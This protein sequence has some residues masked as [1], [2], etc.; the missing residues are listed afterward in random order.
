MPFHFQIR[1]GIQHAAA[2]NLDEPRL[3]ATVVD[4]WRAGTPIEVGDKEWD[5][6]ESKLRILE[7]PELEPSRLDFGRGWDEA[8]RTAREVTDEMLAE[9]SSHG[10]IAV[11][12]ESQTNG[13]AV[14]RVLTELGAT[15]A[16]WSPLRAR[17]VASASTSVERTLDGID[18]TACAIVCET[19][20]PDASWSFDAGLAVGALGPHAVFVRLAG[21]PAAPGDVVSVALDPGDSATW[22]GLAERL[23]QIGL[24]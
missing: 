10:A 9:V 16:D 13:E 8:T 17:I 3:R 12:S 22:H 5:P 23:R 24:G 18:A 6:R 19:A 11:I 2:F 20:N 14:A 21:A 1:R 7:G 4:P 15:G